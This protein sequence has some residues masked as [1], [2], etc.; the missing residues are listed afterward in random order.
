LSALASRA[1]FSPRSDWWDRLV[2]PVLQEFSQSFG[3]VFTSRE[4]CLI[5]DV[6][7][8]LPDLPIVFEQRDCSP[9][10]ILMDNEGEIKVLDWE[11]SEPNGLPLLDLIYF[12]TYLSF[13]VNGIMESREYAQA[14]P[15]VFN[16]QSSIGRIN[17]E[18]LEK[19][20]VEMNL[21]PSVIAPLR[22]LTW[23]IHS[24]PEY[25]RAM[26]DSGG[27]PSPSGLRLGLFATL[28]RE[29]IQLYSKV[30]G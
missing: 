21:D 7:N 23:L 11:S 27:M 10:N 30:D 4:R 14:Y 8:R 26:D 28:I 19:Y 18:C 6:L 20:C 9:W 15:D 3:S 17:Y 12:L 1:R 24:R 13:F 29:E 25:Q 5:H 2:Q 22:L 16:P